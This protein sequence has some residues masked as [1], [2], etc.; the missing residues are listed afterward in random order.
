MLT[1][2]YCEKCERQGLRVYGYKNAIPLLSKKGHLKTECNS[3]G[4]KR[5]ILFESFSDDFIK[6]AV[7]EIT[8]KGT[9][10]EENDNGIYEDENGFFYSFGSDNVPYAQRDDE[11]GYFNFGDKDPDEDDDYYK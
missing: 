8:S 4:H 5:N 10:I 3:C 11:E 9:I 2:H 6:E 1:N 7:L